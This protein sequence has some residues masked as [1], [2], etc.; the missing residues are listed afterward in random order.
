MAQIDSI[1]DDEREARYHF[2]ATY[3]AKAE[4][5]VGDWIVY[6]EP[7][8]KG[9]AEDRT[10]GRLS[11]IAVA[12]VQGIRS[13]RKRPGYFYADVSDYLEF[14]H[15]VPFR[16]GGFYYESALK[17]SDGGTSKGAFGRAVRTM[18]DAEF[19]LILTSGFAPLV[20]E[21]ALAKRTDITLPP[22]FADEPASFDRPI[23]ERLIR[24]PFRDAAF[25]VA[26][27][28][29]YADTCALTGLKIVNG[30]GR[31]EVQAAHIRPVAQAGPDSVRNGLALSS[32]AHWMFDRGLVA[33]DENYQVLKAK[34]ATPD[35]L[36]RLLLPSGAIQLPKRSEWRPHPQFLRWHRDHV[37]KG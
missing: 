27:K 2:P 4:Q 3:L 12:K 10:G 20:S 30:G 29:A 14:D 26:V 7:R 17:R 36:S 34:A 5:T 21:Q 31:T 23:V 18:P 11:Y 25:S 32:T 28:Q 37:F 15:A 16:E 6:Y 13:D 9:G 19:D 35:A 33:I 22:G 24:R 8:R 1:Y